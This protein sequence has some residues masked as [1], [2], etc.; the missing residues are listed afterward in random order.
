[1]E[2]D[3]EGRTVRGRPDGGP[4]RVGLEAAEPQTRRR[5]LLHAHAARTGVCEGRKLPPG[6]PLQRSMPGGQTPHYTGGFSLFS[7]FFSF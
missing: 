5:P 1:M 2:E 4:E 7:V 6:E 3:S